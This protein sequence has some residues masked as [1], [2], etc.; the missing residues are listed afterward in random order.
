MNI[1]L[2]VLIFAAGIGVG[3]LMKVR[4]VIKFDKYD[5]TIYVNQDEVTEKIVYTLELDEYPEKLKFK[6][7]VVFKVDTSE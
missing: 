4:K 7:L 1:V 6:K 5:G 2:Y 3:L